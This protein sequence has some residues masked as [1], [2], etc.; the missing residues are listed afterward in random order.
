MPHGWE[1]GGKPNGVHASHQSRFGFFL[2]TCAKGDMRQ[3]AD[4]I[5]IHGDEIREIP[6][7]EMARARH[8][9]IDELIAALRHERPLVHSGRRC[10]ASIEAC[11]AMLQSSTERREIMLRHQ[12]P[13][14]EDSAPGP[15]P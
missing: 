2:V 3:S 9:E 11:L 4:G 8:A 7:D 15:I 14:S 13:L 1:K 5:L 10:K 12:V 6:L